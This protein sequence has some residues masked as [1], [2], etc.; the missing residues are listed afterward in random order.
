[1]PVLDGDGAVTEEAAATWARKIIDTLLK[2]HNRN[3]FIGAPALIP[4]TLVAGS[5]SLLHMI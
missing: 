5:D 1:M 4:R 2:C 3:V